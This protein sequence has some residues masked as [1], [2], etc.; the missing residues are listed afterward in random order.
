MKFYTV[1]QFFLLSLIV[2][3]THAMQHDILPQINEAQNVLIDGRLSENQANATLDTYSQSLE[4]LACGDMENASVKKRALEIMRKEKGILESKGYPNT[5]SYFYALCELNHG[6]QELTSGLFKRA[7]FYGIFE[8]IGLCPNKKDQ[9]RLKNNG[10]YNPELIAVTMGLAHKYLKDHP[11]PANKYS[12]RE[13]LTLQ[14]NYFS[15]PIQDALQS[16]S[17]NEHINQKDKVVINL[18]V[19][20][21]GRLYDD[22]VKDPEFKKEYFGETMQKAT[23]LLEK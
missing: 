21:L 7:L 8:D 3:K 15:H 13:T 9:Q 22:F 1:F 19:N 2:Y 11:K 10:F 4:K 5:Q 16:L 14:I 6:D 23:N 12:E 18:M 20:G 17:S